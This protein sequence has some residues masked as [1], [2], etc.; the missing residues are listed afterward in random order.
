MRIVFLHG[1]ESGPQ[2]SKYRALAAAFENVTAPDCE[3]VFD[4]EERLQIIIQHLGDEP[5]LLVGSSFG[6]LA[7]CL[8]HGR[9]PDLVLGAVLCAP[10]LHRPEAEELMGG[11]DVP[12]VIIHGTQ[13]T[14]VPIQASRAYAE[15][16]GLPLIEVSDNHRLSESAGLMIDQVRAVQSS[17]MQA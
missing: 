13:D 11:L 14:V 17:I 2:G 4:M 8:V 16:Y 1:L 9:R 5:A 12:S 10:A 3:G 7:A 15:A 6:G